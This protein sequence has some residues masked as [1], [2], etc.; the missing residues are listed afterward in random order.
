MQHSNVTD[1][2]RNICQLSQNSSGQ[3]LPQVGAG[4]VEA[5]SVHSSDHAETSPDLQ[6]CSNSQWK[7]RADETKASRH[8]LHRASING[9]W[10]TVKM[11]LADG[12]NVNQRDK[13]SLTPLHLAAWY[14]QESVVKLLLRLGANVNAV[15]R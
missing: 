10:N 6:K 8:A 4:I 9:K 12:E 15:D 5:S 13:F 7:T 1:H 3:M 11:L 2:N 14:G